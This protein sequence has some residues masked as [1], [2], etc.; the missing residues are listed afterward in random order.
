MPPQLL[1]YFFGYSKLL[2]HYD[3]MGRRL[4]PAFSLRAY[5]DE[6]LAHGMSWSTFCG[7]RC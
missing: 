1:T 5:N 6:V 2:A 4:G 7:R 3:K